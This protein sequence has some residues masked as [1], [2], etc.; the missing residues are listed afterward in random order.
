M[1]T[2]TEPGSCFDGLGMRARKPTHLAVSLS[3]GE[4][5]VRRLYRAVALLDL[6]HPAV[7]RRQHL[8]GIAGND[9]VDDRRGVKDQTK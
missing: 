7:D 4:G 6:Q 1:T 9:E 2:V 3:K 8:A 5:S